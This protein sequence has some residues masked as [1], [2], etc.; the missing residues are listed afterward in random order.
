MLT[1]CQSRRRLMNHVCGMHGT[2]VK[3]RE[4]VEGGGGAV[5]R[6]L[7]RGQVKWLYQVK[8]DH[9]NLSLLCPRWGDLRW[10]TG[11]LTAASAVLSDLR[12]RERASVS[13]VV[14]YIIIVRSDQL[15]DFLA[16]TCVINIYYTNLH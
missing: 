3:V 15:P 2:R 11:S 10:H 4:G 9:Q 1:L 5:L 8:W 12:G 6:R 7:G 16:D 14:P 13:A